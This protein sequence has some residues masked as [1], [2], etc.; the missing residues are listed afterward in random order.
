M[1]ICVNH[2]GEGE[3]REVIG[4]ENVTALSGLDL[5]GHEHERWGRHP[6][7]WKKSGEAVGCE[8]GVRK[9]G[10]GDTA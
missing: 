9:K 7:Y 10:W 4:D 3:T 2:S 1:R 8:L 5:L 6:R